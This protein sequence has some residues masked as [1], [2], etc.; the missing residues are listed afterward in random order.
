M[1][2]TE[3]D[4][5]VMQRHGAGP[6]GLTPGSVCQAAEE[7]LKRCMRNAQRR[8]MPA[9]TKD[10]FEPY[11]FAGRHVV[12]VMNGASKKIP[13]GSG[14]AAELLTIAL[15]DA[16]RRNASYGI[17]INRCNTRRLYGDPDLLRA[18]IAHMKAQPAKERLTR[19]NNNP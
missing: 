8:Q 7:D 11:A 12:R 2:G 10:D 16:M 1:G 6:S 15:A 14:T 3:A 13:P 18:A 9:F 19:A 4:N 5:E 17:T